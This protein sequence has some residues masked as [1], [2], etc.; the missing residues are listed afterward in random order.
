MTWAGW[1][2]IACLAYA[3]VAGLR[4]V[5]SVDLLVLPERGHRVQ[6]LALLRL[7]QAT[8]RFE[9]GIAACSAFMGAWT[10]ALTVGGYGAM[11]WVGL[12]LYRRHGVAPWWAPS[13]DRRPTRLP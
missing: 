12:R 9:L 6:R 5:S 2:S 7:G 3:A 11:W 8:I 4:G 10:A 1:A 13:L